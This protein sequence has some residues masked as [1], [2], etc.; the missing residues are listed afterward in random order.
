MET[1][2]RLHLPFILDKLTE[3]RGN[4]FPIAIIQQCQRPE[5]NKLLKLV[6]KML[7]KTQ[8]TGPKHKALRYSVMEFI[9][10]SEHPRIE[11][12]RLQYEET[13]G[14]VN[15]ETWNNYWKRMLRDGTW[16]DY[17]FVQATAWYLQLDIWIIATSNTENSPYIAI[18]GNLENEN[19]PCSGPIITLGTKSNSHYQS[20]L[21]IE[22]FH[23]E[24]RTNNP[25]PEEAREMFNKVSKPCTEETA[26]VGVKPEANESIQVNK[27]VNTTGTCDSK[28]PQKNKSSEVSDDLKLSRTKPLQSKYTESC[29]VASKTKKQNTELEKNVSKTSIK[30]TNGYAPLI[31]IYTMEGNLYSEGHHMTIS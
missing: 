4:C 16:V 28:E 14:I 7:V 1:V 10:K 23:L 2:N 8:R 26:A 12:F 22:M 30:A 15:R 17:W 18:S 20:L 11:R 13:D 5:I 29:D 3:G 24:F 27:N 19:I 21:P 31:Y 6:T 9:K 25:Q